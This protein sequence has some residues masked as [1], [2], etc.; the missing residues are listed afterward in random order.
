M[1]RTRR[2]EPRNPE[3]AAP[4]PARR[5][6]LLENLAADAHHGQADKQ[7]VP[8][9]EHLRAV[10]DSVSPEAKPVALL[11]DALEDTHL[12]EEDL[13]AVLTPDELA[14]VKV[15]TRDDH[16][17]S[18]GTYERY[19]ERIATAEGTPGELARTVK[20][21]DLEHNLGR[22]TPALETLRARYEW[23]PERLG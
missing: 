5:L 18:E 19:V 23:A 6:Q 16:D 9:I 12:S 17:Q 4:L 11:H 2:G 15:L 20:R 3:L 7:G 21:A 10:A 22:L 8:Y 13:N 14:A 1:K